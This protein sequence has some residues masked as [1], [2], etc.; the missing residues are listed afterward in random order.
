M[1]FSRLPGDTAWGRF[2]TV[3]TVPVDTP[4]AHATSTSF[5]P[6]VRAAPFAGR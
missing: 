6:G 4:A 3:E 1:T 2:S 5:T